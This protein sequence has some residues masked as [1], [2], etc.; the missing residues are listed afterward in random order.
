MSWAED[1][2]RAEKEAMRREMI[3]EEKREERKMSEDIEYA[4]DRYYSIETLSV[5]L[6]GLERHLDRLG[7]QFTRK[8]VLELL[9]DI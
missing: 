7:Y 5:A 8:Q 3:E 2:L 9:E 6:E 4:L 1:D